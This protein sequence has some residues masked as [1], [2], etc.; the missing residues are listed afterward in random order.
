MSERLRR[1]YWV[2][3]II[4]N[5]SV[6][7]TTNEKTLEDNARLVNQEKD[8]QEWLKNLSVGKNGYIDEY[9]QR[10]TE[11]N[12]QRRDLWEVVRK[13]ENQ[14]F[15]QVAAHKETH[16]LTNSILQLYEILPLILN[17]SNNT[18]MLSDLYKD[19]NKFIP[20]G[21]C[22]VNSELL[23]DYKNFTYSW[24]HTIKYTQVI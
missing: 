1:A 3:N 2:Q 20:R 15:V 13:Y 5:P 6:L 12:E 16:A 24:C 14:P 7:F 9:R 17:N 10:I 8:A 11:L 19:T 21:F 4:H 23:I 22:L 18:K